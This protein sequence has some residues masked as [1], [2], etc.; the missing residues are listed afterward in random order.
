MDRRMYGCM[1]V[2]V[3][4]W[5]YGMDVWMRGCVDYYTDIWTHTHTHIYIYI[6]MIGYLDKLLNRRILF[7][8][9]SHVRRSQRGPQM[10]AGRLY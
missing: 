1:D 2:S 6:H 8:S 4:V 10:R 9:T 3:D 5:M 7:R